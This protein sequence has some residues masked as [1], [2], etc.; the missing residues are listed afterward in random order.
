VPYNSSLSLLVPIAKVC[1]DKTT[2]ALKN[3]GVSEDPNQEKFKRLDVIKKM[4]I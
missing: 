3:F 2:A 4:R 1:L